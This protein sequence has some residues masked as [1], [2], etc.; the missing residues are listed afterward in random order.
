V[1]TF[2]DTGGGGIG[3]RGVSA[4]WTW[5]FVHYEQSDAFGALRS[6]VLHCCCYLVFCLVPRGV[7]KPFPRGRRM[8]RR[9]ISD[10][11]MP[12]TPG[13]TTR[14]ARREPRTIRN[15][16]RRTTTRL[17]GSLALPDATDIQADYKIS[18]AGAS[19]SRNDA[20]RTTNWLGGSLGLPAQRIGRASDSGGYYRIERA[21]SCVKLHR[22]RRSRRK[23]GRRGSTGFSRRGAF[24]WIST[25]RCGTFWES[26]P[27]KS[28]RG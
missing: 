5:Q 9:E 17:G 11:R 8:T 3:R 6:N 7:N 12:P 10:S 21:N 15:D 28:L 22:S 14:S 19:H 4:E 20:R 25:D 2:V 13:R 1:I 16:A 23:K 26:G 24:S 18:S 27:S